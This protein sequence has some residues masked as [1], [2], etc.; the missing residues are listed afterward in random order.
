MY[1][2]ACFP[3]KMADTR[4]Y[5]T[6]PLWYHSVHSKTAALASDG[7]QSAYIILASRLLLLLLRLL[8][9]RSACFTTSNGLFHA[10]TGGLAQ[11]VGGFR[12]GLGLLQVSLQPFDKDFSS[13]GC[14]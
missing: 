3:P 6:E 4:L 5:A 9:W 14:A 8:Q 1:L 11:L 12:R 13:A 7:R 10:S 2:R